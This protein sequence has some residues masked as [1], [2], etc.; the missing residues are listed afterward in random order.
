MDFSVSGRMEL[1]R[2]KDGFRSVFKG[3]VGLGETNSRVRLQTVDDVDNILQ[4]SN[5]NGGTW[6][7]VCD[8][9]FSQ[10][11]AAVACREMGFNGVQNFDIAITVNGDDVFGL[12]DLDCNGDEASIFDCTHQ[13]W[14][15]EN[16]ADYEHVQLTCN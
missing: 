16:C 13:D 3:E 4:A 8:D 14:T 2:L 5:D 7:S 9:D 1:I 10:E 6:L 11:N 15:I 12:D